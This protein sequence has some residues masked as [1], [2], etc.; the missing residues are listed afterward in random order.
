VAISCKI[1]NQ[2][3]THC[4][5]LFLFLVG[6]NTS[7]QAQFEPT[8]EGQ[9][10]YHYYLNLQFDS[11]STIIQNLPDRPY[12]LY[13]QS[14]MEVTKIFLADDPELF[15]STKYLE[16]DILKNVSA[17]D[18][19]AKTTQFLESE[20]KIQWAILK[21]KFG[22]EFAAFWNMRQAYHKT[23]KNLKE[24][25]AFL[26][27]QKSMGLLQILF[28]IV[29][30][31]YSWVLSLFGIDG[32]IETGL[33]LLKTS[34]NAKSVFQ[35]ESQMLVALLNTYLLNQQEMG[36]QNISEV[37]ANHHL[38]LLDYAYCLI[39]I[40]NA[41][42]EEALTVL[43]EAGSYHQQPYKLPQ[44]YYL[45]G[46]IYLQKGLL[47]DAIKNYE[48]FIANQNGLSLIKDA[49]YK[50][51]ICHYIQGENTLANNSFKQ[52]LASGWTKNE[53]DQY[54]QTQIENANYAQKDLYRL[55]YATDGGYYDEALKIQRDISSDSLSTQDLCEYYYRS[56]RLFQN[57]KS[58]PEAISYYLKA[59]KTQQDNEWYFAPNAALQLAKIYVD[60]E[61][62]GKARKYLELVFTYK[63][64]PYQKSIRQKAKNLVKSL[65]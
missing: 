10:A 34:A 55:R 65:D 35:L 48:K 12:A 14:L 27:S 29:P 53:A 38:I 17:Q 3:A 1:F 5:R 39:A 33:T 31:N 43:E 9:Q 62:D 16:S 24:Y 13:L 57:L 7:A 45:L 58:E 44:L 54:A 42:S 20:I 36:L 46:E 23:R 19:N 8:P 37:Q 21:M 28:G 61:N 30:E 49:C 6:F 52:A 15:K 11:C 4:V 50:I 40:K 41:K 18:F 51:G 2:K 59:I 64:H 60:V 32:D 63:N 56:A 47:P 26:A 25:P 22:D